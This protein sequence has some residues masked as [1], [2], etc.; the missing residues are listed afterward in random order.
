MFLS[1]S[2]INKNSFR[3]SELIGNEQI[4]R[5]H[6]NFSIIKRFEVYEII[7]E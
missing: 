3:N 1:E 5:K 4:K 6:V 7:C 2:I